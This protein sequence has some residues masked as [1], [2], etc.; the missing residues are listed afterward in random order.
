MDKVPLR[1]RKV[2]EPPGECLPDQEILERLI[3]KVKE[4]MGE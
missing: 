4:K 3:E 1:L 2:K